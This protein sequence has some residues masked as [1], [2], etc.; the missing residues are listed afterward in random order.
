MKFSIVTGA[1]RTVAVGMLAV[2]A[3]Q[4]LAHAKNPYQPLLDVPHAAV[5]AVYA[6]TA[7]ASEGITIANTMT[8]TFIHLP[9]LP[10]D[11]P[12]QS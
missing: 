6:T 5:A 8:D 4:V 9:P 12:R 7:V 11:T 3:Q 1:K 10:R 2:G